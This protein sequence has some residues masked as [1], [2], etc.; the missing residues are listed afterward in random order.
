MN[1]NSLRLLQPVLLTLLT[2]FSLVAHS[3]ESTTKL[4]DALLFH[5]SF[6]KGLNADVAAG[7]P[8]FYH[9]P[10]GNRKEARPGLPEDNLVT[11]APGEGRFGDALRFHKKTRPIFFRGEK[12]LGYRT[13][14]W[15][16][17]VSLWLRLDPDKDLEPGYCDPL[18]F[19]GQ[20]WEEGN[21]FI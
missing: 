5:A 7:D 8:G 20:A 15:N 12:N 16:G 18:Q 13:N 1:S 17:A 9:A 3:A 10:T 2:G 6:D 4:A 11:L 19:V 21:M 14:G